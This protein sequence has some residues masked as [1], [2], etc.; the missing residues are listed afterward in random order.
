MSLGQ[1]IKR[2]AIQVTLHLS[3]W[4]NYSIWVDESGLQCPGAQRQFT[5]VEDTNRYGSPFLMETTHRKTLSTPFLL[6]S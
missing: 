2:A 6:A 4:P 1:A 3:N 5:D